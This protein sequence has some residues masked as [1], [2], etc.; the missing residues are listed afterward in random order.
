MEK[1]TS[2]GWP[3]WEEP[4]PVPNDLTEREMKAANE[5]A[6]RLRNTP[7]GRRGLEV[8]KF[9]REECVDQHKILSHLAKR[10]A[11]KRKSNKKRGI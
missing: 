8:V 3:Q 7:Y 2:R 10:A 1:I 4:D 6:A 9:C 11:A 5:L